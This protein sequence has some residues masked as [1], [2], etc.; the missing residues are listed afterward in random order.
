MLQPTAV[1]YETQEILAYSTYIQPIPASAPASTTKVNTLVAAICCSIAALVF[2]STI[3]ILKFRNR[4][5]S[6]LS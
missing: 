3:V 4:L 2:F 1:P 5:T 6:S